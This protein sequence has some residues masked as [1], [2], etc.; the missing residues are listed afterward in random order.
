M[1]MDELQETV[2]FDEQ[3]AEA[4]KRIQETQTLFIDEIGMLSKVMFE[5]V[6]LLCRLVKDKKLYFGGLQV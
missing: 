3:F 5:K 2:L 1:T 6:E 4:R